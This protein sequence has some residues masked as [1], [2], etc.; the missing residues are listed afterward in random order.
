MASERVQRQ[1]DRLLDEAE[2]AFAQGDWRRLEGHARRVLLLD[3]ENRDAV[4]FLTAAE[5]ALG[6]A[7]LLEAPPAPEQAHG[8]QADTTSRDLQ[9]AGVGE[10]EAER[11]QLTVMFCDLQGST[12]LSQQLDPEELR[13]VLRGYQDVCAQ[14]ISRFE[15]HIAKYLGDGLLAYFGYP[16]AHE[17]DPQRAVR[18]GLS[19]VEEMQGLNAR[20]REDKNIELAVRL[21]IHTGLVV[22]GEMGGGETRE[23]MAIVG[24]TPNIAARL[25]E[26]AG[27]N[28]L[29][30]SDVT[31]RLIEGFFLCEGL[32]SRSLKGISQ[33]MELFRVVAE[34]GAQSPFDVA[35]A[36]EL[37]PLVGREQEV[38]LLLDRWDQVN[39]GYGQV[40]LLSGEAGIGKSRLV[41]TLDERLAMKPPI[42]QQL[43][44]SP[45]HQNSA[46]YPMVSFL[47]RWLRFRREDSPEESLGKLELALEGFSFPLAE[48]V[49]LLGGLLKVPLDDR[50]PSLYLSPEGQRDRTLELLVAL[51]LETARERPV[52]CVVEDLHW[53]DPSTLEFLGLLL[54]WAPTSKVLAVFTFRPEFSPPWTGRTHMTQINLNRL[55][56]RQ[57]LQMVDRL[58][59]G[60]AMPEVVLSQ[61]ASKSDGVPLFV[62]EL[63]RMV[64]E[65][66]LVKE[67]D[68]HYALTGPLPPLAIPSTLQDSLT[69]RL[70]RLGSAREVAQ[71]GAVLGRG[72]TYELIQYVSPL[73]ESTLR[74]YLEQLVKAEFLYQ[75]GLPPEATYTFR[76]ALVQDAA[77][78]SLLKGRRQEYHRQVAQVLEERFS[79]IAEAQPELLA[80]HYSEAGIDEKAVYYFQRA[81]ERAL[82][83]YAHGEA[84]T[85]FQRGLAAKEG[86]EMDA[87]TAALLFGLVRAQAATLETHEQGD[88]VVSLVRAF[89]F[90]ADA[91]DVDRAVA[92]AEYPL[93]TPSFRLPG[94]PQLV[95]RALSMVAPESHAAGRL[96]SRYGWF[97]GMEQA[98]YGG[99]RDAFARAMAIA[100]RESDPGLEMR[101][102]ANA[103]EVEAYYNHGEESLQNGLRAVALAGRVDD[104]DAELLAR[105]WISFRQLIVG[106][107][108]AASLHAAAMLGLAN[109][110]GH[111]FYLART[112]FVNEALSR[113]KGEWQFARNFSDR[114]LTLSPREPRLLAARLALE[115]ETRN[116]PEGETHLERL[117]EAAR[118]TAPGP[119]NFYAIAAM[120]VPAV[121]RITGVAN[122]MDLAESLTAAVLSSPSVTPL[123]GMIASI[124]AALTA[125]LRGD[126]TAAKKYYPVLRSQRGTIMVFLI[127]AD[128]LLGLLANTMDQFDVASGHFEDALA[129][130]RKAGYRPELAW[131]CCDYADALLQRNSEGDRQKAKSLLDESLAISSELGMRPLMER[132]QGRRERLTA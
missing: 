3:A 79:D 19:I 2:E 81:G 34:S 108:S 73:N 21:G 62:E 126:V 25:Q 78:Q 127:A 92:V 33:P 85:L 111:H 46:F 84:L 65:S 104:P 37:T 88:T 11:R 121:S 28:S 101:T 118:I 1:I 56:R 12:A 91:G 18:A 63:T 54:D 31:F 47:E 55:T 131:T 57:A 20:L 105:Y 61:V 130:C 106:E 80:H 69:A 125:V 9:T 72:F 77:Y 53:A 97:M 35:S 132:V 17:D 59:G 122:R 6:D 10:P 4:S 114:G 76:H 14:A 36:A 128:R 115:F 90:Y 86:R 32:G 113:L 23:A 107:S 49:P 100:Q 13:D 82:A 15:G 41:Q 96:Q 117:L 93:Y 8:Q 39:D 110:L 116:I 43:R 70:D 7:A 123:T 68:D 44:C 42:R 94:V 103:A 52:L 83:T 51:L 30:V 38:G 60:K 109:R 26:A 89:D 27:P 58:T 16:Q 119:S 50:Y 29:V 112:L 40:V 64:V 129:F 71:L 66:G 75:W 5:R 48:A 67:V 99:A 45:Y 124:G 87:E 74:R 98:D 95:T 120:M 102:L 24:D 22:A